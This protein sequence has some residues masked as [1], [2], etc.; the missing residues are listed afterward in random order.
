MDDR[1]DVA[2]AAGADGAHLGQQDLPVAAARAAFGER[3]VLGATVHGPE[4]VAQAAL[5]D[6]VGLGTVFPSRT[7]P[8]LPARGLELIRELVPRL[9]PLPVFAVGGIDA[10]RARAC[11]Q[12][13]ADGVA[14]GAAITAAPDIEAATRQLLAALGAT[15]SP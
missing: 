11:L 13:G 4:E 14:V 15:T 10:A 5:A 1:P 7:R 3:L 8:E 12:A 2:L 9:R 6:Y